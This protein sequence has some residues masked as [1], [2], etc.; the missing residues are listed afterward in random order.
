MA[1]T[2]ILLLLT[3]LA[4]CAARQPLVV[5]PVARPL[6]TLCIERNARVKLRYVLP[7]L[8]DQLTARGVEVRTVEPDAVPET[9]TA[10]ATYRALRASS[11]YVAYLDFDIRDESGPNGSIRFRAPPAGKDGFDPFIPFN[12]QLTPMFDQL[13]GPAP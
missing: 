9:C 1:R 11:T 2:G 12:Q 8:R 6:E 3:L 5:T 7:D 4:A 13:L 10:R